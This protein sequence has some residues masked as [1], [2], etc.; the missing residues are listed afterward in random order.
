M[1]IYVQFLAGICS[2]WLEYQTLSAQ[3]RV[4]SQELTPTNSNSNIALR[5]YRYLITIHLLDHSATRHILTMQIPDVSGNRMPSVSF[6]KR[7]SSQFFSVIFWKPS[8]NT[9]LFL[10]LRLRA[11]G[12]SNSPTR[13]QP[14]KPS[15]APEILFEGRMPTGMITL[16]SA[17]HL[18][19]ALCDVANQNRRNWTKTSS[20]FWTI[21]LQVVLTLHK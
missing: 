19:A 15:N 10:L 18:I 2:P 4:R 9:V 11:L 6:I 14:W 12:W 3:V 5:N 13:W 8:C 1:A 16:R 7:V 17:L 20:K 21:P